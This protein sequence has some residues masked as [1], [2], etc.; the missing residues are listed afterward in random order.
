LRTDLSNSSVEKT[1]FFNSFVI[2]K[3][4]LLSENKVETSSFLVE[5]IK[6]HLF[7]FLQN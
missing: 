3:S 1:S 2:L 6:C 4:M 7:G 5:L